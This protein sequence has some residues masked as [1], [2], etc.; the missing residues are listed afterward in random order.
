MVVCLDL[1][2]DFMQDGKR[3]SF[4]RSKSGYVVGD[5]ELLKWMQ[6]WFEDKGPS[7]VEAVWDGGSDWGHAVINDDNLEVIKEVGDVACR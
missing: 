5:G 1:R 2:E 3:D 7:F 4:K 6:N